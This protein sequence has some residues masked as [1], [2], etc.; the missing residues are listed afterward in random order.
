M[1]LFHNM[2]SPSNL[3]VRI[4]TGINEMIYFTL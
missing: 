3:P 4:V 1:T 2:V